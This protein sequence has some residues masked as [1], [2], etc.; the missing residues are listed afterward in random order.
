MGEFYGVKNNVKSSC[1]YISANVPL[2]KYSLILSFF[3]EACSTRNGILNFHNA[4]VWED[5]DCYL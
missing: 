2:L 3:D 4:F 1:K 5:E